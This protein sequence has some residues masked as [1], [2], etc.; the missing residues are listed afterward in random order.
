M[1][2]LRHWWWRVNPRRTSYGLVDLD[3]GCQDVVDRHGYVV[4][5]EHDHVACSRKLPEA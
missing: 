4:D 5:R 1:Y 3:C 2:K